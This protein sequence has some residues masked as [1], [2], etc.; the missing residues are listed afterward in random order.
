MSDSEVKTFPSYI[1]RVSHDS[2]LPP[3]GHNHLEQEMIP[4][5]DDSDSKRVSGNSMEEGTFSS[6]SLEPFFYQMLVEKLI[7]SRPIFLI[8]SYPRR[9]FKPTDK[10]ENMLRIISNFV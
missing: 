3:L 7:V 6:G 9:R 1:M 5:S 8:T 4:I 10:G 2:H